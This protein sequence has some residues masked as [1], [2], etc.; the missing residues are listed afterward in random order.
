VSELG[1]LG[2]RARPGAHGRDATVWVCVG[3]HWRAGR[4]LAA[5]VE[6][7]LVRHLLPGKGTSVDTVVWAQLSAYERREYVVQLDK[8]DSDGRGPMPVRIG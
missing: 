3:G 4:V 8:D 1:A 6:A 7:V 5:S 2:Q